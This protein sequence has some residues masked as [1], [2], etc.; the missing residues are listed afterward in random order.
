MWCVADMFESAELFLLEP[1]LHTYGRQMKIAKTE[2]LSGDF[3]IQA[4]KEEFHFLQFI[5]VID[6]LWI[7]HEIKRNWKYMFLPMRKI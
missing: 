4:R 5:L 6:R 1:F 2:D 7:Q 3:G